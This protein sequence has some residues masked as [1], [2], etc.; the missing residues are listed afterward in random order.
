MTSADRDQAAS[1]ANR[2]VDRP[3]TML[4]LDLIPDPAHGSVHFL[5]GADAMRVVQ[6]ALSERNG[7]P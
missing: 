7:K 3:S 4:L 5:F 1:T 6:A 2:R